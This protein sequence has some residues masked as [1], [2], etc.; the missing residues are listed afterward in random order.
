MRCSLDC[1]GDIQTNYSM[2]RDC[3]SFEEEGSVELVRLLSR[4]RL[5]RAQSVKLLGRMIFAMMGFK[6]D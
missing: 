1:D 2:L 3:L 5:C 4:S 6:V